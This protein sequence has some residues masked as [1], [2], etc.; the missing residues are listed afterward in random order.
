MILKIIFLKTSLTEN[1]L[2][3]NEE[4]GYFRIYLIYLSIAVES[5]NII[6]TVGNFCVIKYP[7][8]RVLKNSNSKRSEKRINN[9]IIRVTVLNLLQIYLHATDF[10]HR[11]QI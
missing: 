8:P 5:T 10:K 6:Q 7:Y 3:Y 4:F 11:K 9:I 1:N 2:I